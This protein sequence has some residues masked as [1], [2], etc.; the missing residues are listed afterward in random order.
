MVKCTQTHQYLGY[1]PQILYNS[2]IP[3]NRFSIFTKGCHKIHFPTIL[4]YMQTHGAYVVRDITVLIN[5]IS[6]ED[7][8]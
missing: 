7:K 8:I 6:K 5:K 1:C 2:I 4:T 3:F